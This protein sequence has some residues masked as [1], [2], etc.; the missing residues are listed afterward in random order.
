[1]K[2]GFTLIELL[3]VIA[4]IAILAAMLLPALK[5]VQERGRQ[6]LCQNNLKQI[7][8][9][10]SL[11][12]NDANGWL[13]PVD[14]WQVQ[15]WPSI[16]DEYLGGEGRD[17]HWH[18]VTNECWACPTNNP[19]GLDMLK[20]RPR[21]G[22]PSYNGSIS[23]EYSGYAGATALRK[24]R[25]IQLLRPSTGVYVVEVRDHNTGAYGPVTSVSYASYG[26][27]NWC[28]AGHNMGGN[29]LFTDC[30]ASWASVSDPIYSPSATVAK[31]YWYPH[32]A[33]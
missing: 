9:G 32:E 26:F 3:V 10:L 28:F 7:G 18:A 15:Y 16:I 4:I 5:G 6:L 13:Y 11:Y 25:N 33:E 31:P 23:G 12:Q 30:H 14:I 1:M 8:T 20:K 24:V 27:S 2:K 22:A 17:I 21:T 19:G 29:V